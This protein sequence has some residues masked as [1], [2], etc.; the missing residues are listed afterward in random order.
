MKSLQIYNYKLI[1]FKVDNIVF[2]LFSVMN[3]INKKI[4]MP[5]KYC[6]IT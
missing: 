1:K 2:I 6:G 5:Q 3:T 4:I